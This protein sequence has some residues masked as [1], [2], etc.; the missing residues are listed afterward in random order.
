VPDDVRGGQ[1]PAW[2]LHS[3]VGPALRGLRPVRG[4]AV[5]DQAMHDGEQRGVP[6]VPG[7][8]GK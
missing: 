5:P 8:Y 2:H 4:G 6:G 1:V 7:G 3:D